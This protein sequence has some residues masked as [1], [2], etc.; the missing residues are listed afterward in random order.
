MPNFILR[1]EELQDADILNYYVGTIHDESLLEDLETPI[2]CLL[3]GSRGVGKSFLFKVLKQRLLLAFA[4]KKIL[5]V[6]VTF[7]NSPFLKT[8]CE[9]AFYYW[10]LARITT[11]IVRALKRAGALSSRTSAAAR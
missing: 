4:E 6:M 8:D 5:P 10:M 2:P 7:R 3:E 1:S 11:E 9:S